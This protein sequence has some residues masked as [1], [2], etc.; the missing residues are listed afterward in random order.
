MVLALNR[1][2]PARFVAHP[3]VRLGTFAEVD[4]STYEYQE[5][6][7]A[8]GDNGNGGVA[9]A[10]W[11]PPRPTLEVA[12]DLPAQ[13]EF[14][15]RV[16]DTEKAQRLVAAVELVSPANKDR[17]EHRRAFVTKCV[18]LLQNQVSV[19][20]VDV[21]TN[22][23]NNLYGEML[24]EIGQSDPS[25]GEEPSAIYAVSCRATKTGFKP[26]D[27][28]QLQTW[29]HPLQVGQPLPTLPLWLTSNYS[30]PLEL[31]E[32]YEDTCKGLRVI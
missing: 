15:V 18:A 13:D 23:N 28:W 17:P 9:T 5:H 24:D 16:Y 10:V 1:K 29:L 31:E 6:A 12:T 20:I 14:E 3:R 30:V 8:L 7:T 25:L 26:S 27:G 2:L 11:A 19:T 4:V 32:T 22:R 21:V